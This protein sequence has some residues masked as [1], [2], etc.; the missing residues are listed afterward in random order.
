MNSQVR[1]FELCVVTKRNIVSQAF[2]IL[3][4]ASIRNILIYLSLANIEFMG[5]IFG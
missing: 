4:M 3:P 5:C 2:T 1:T